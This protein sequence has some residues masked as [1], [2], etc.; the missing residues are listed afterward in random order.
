MRKAYCGISKV[1][2]GQK[3]GSMKECA[4]SGQIRYYGL[5]KIDTKLVE[6][7]KSSKKGQSKRNT[8]IEQ[9]AGIKGKINAITKAFKVE[10]D[11][12]KK[13]QLNEQYKKLVVELKKLNA[14]L[15]KLSTGRVVS[16]QTRSRKGSKKRSSK[17]SSKKTSRKS[18]KRRKTSKKSKRSRQT[19]KSKR[20]SKKY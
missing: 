15:A 14:E 11:I 7:A 20:K 18:S 8:L 17:R 19:R 3:R 5:K 2:K 16:K 12:K 6:Y 9:K 1:P 13:K 4:V 10:K